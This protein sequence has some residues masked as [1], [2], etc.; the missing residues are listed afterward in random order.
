MLELAYY[1]GFDVSATFP[2]AVLLSSCYRYVCMIG[3]TEYVCIMSSAL[4]NRINAK[5]SKSL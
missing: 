5:Y 2:A 4:L 3:Y 1:A